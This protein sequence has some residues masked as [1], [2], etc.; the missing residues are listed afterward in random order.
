M[1]LSANQKKAGPQKGR[2]PVDKSQPKGGDGQGIGG[3]GAKK[4]SAI[5]SSHVTRSM[6]G[7]ASKPKGRVIEGQHVRGTKKIKS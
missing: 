3:L 6:P 5:H 2:F 1:T 4:D 7:N